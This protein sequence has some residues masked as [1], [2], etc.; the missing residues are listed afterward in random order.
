ML[1]ENAICPRSSLGQQAED[2]QPDQKRIRRSPR[3]QSER[4]V[5]RVLLWP[6]KPLT[7]LQERRTQLLNRCERELNLRLDPGDPG[8]PKLARSLDRV[9][10]QRRLADARFATHHQHTPAAAARAV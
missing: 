10:E 5:K 3:T 6:R 2:R 4:D 8:D 1:D 9:L 7:K